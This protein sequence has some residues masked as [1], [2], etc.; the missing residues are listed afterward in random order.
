MSKTDC[1]R[2]KIDVIAA[3]SRDLEK[4][5]VKLFTYP[6]I[7]PENDIRSGKL[8]RLFVGYL[9]RDPDGLQAQTII[10]EKDYLS[11]SYQGDHSNYF[12]QCY[13][14]YQKLCKRIHF[15]GEA[16]DKDDFLDML[17]EDGHMKRWNSYLGYIVIKPLTRGI[18]GA[19]LLK[20]YAQRNNRF[21]TAVRKYPVNIFGKQLF[22][23]TMAFTEQDQVVSNCAT[24][25]LWFTF[26]G[27][28]ELFRTRIPDLSDITLS[29]GADAYY[30]TRLFPSKSL[31][32][33]QITRAITANDL[34]PEIVLDNT[35][36]QSNAWLKS[37]IYAYSRMGI[38][39]LLGIDIQ[40]YGGHQ[41]T[42]NGYRFADRQKRSKGPVKFKTESILGD[43]ELV[44]HGIEK[45]YAHDDQLGP[46]SRLEFITETEREPRKSSIAEE[47]Q[48]GNEVGLPST[49]DI[50]NDGVQEKDDMEDN[51]LEQFNTSWW[52]DPRKGNEVLKAYAT[53]VIVP[54]KKSIRL[55]FQNIYDEVAI[56]NK[57]LPKEL[58]NIGYPLEKIQW[59]IYL[60]TKGIYKS[61]LMK[62]L[63]N[64]S[65]PS[66]H[67]S[68]QILFSSI[69]EYIWVVKGYFEVGGVKT[70]LFDIL[71]DAADAIVINNAF[72][73]VF[74]DD[75]FYHSIKKNLLDKKG[76]FQFKSYSSIR[77][78]KSSSKSVKIDTE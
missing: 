76:N 11:L 54:L 51:N 71:Y 47:E 52:K 28:G 1:F 2:D 23:T 61:D 63:R 27:T 19:T 37:I 30:S 7:I 50:K 36:L 32:I 5:L 42:V 58:D 15:F 49:E 74:Y 70:L 72:F 17:A 43:I 3:S 44:S 4:Q 16:F 64:M 48:P 9:F 39:V 31:E 18:F 68:R 78:D 57:C 26:H 20:P 46:F 24:A 56:L 10:E 12:T 67:S 22:L 59:D 77:K 38:P 45:F 33:N 29:A 55:V 75:N 53:H 14:P 13:K 40:E 6:G 60:N 73:T 66:D 8:F 21:Y 41:V 69:P 34:Q 62:E 25:S 65:V 35:Y